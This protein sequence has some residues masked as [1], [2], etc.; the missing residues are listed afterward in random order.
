MKSFKDTV[1][2]NLAGLIVAICTLG[3]VFSFGGAAVGGPW[4]NTIVV[5]LLAIPIMLY[6]L[7]PTLERWITR[8]RSRRNAE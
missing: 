1:I 8:F 6:F 3:I 2:S 4:P 5:G 7:M